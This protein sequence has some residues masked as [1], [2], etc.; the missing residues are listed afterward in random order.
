MVRKLFTILMFLSTT[1]VVGQSI[2]R[3]QN[4]YCDH[5]CNHHQ[6]INYNRYDHENTEI[7]EVG[8]ALHTAGVQ[9]TVAK[10]LPLV[11]VPIAYASN[12]LIYPEQRYVAYSILGVGGVTMFY[13][14][15]RADRN[16]RKAG[17]ILRFTEHGI[18][19]TKN[20]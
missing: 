1:T 8:I 18:G 15:L 11:I 19:F 10:L 4:V 6:Q 17:G 9:Y 2:R 3:K 5:R 16:L 14:S 7:Q 13:L 20:F 12:E